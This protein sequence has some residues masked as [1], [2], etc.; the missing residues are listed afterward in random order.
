[1]SVDPNISDPDLWLGHVFSAQ[2]VA[3]GQVIRRQLRDI[4]RYAGWERFAAEVTR[5][6][7]RAVRNR[8]QIIVFCN[9]DP[10]RRVV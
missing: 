3:K 9:N 2:A 1:M 7:F 4:E 10:I 5:R 8:D 6:G